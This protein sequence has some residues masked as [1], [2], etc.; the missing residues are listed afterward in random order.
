LYALDTELGLPEG[1]TKAE[2]KEA[3][4]GH[5]LAEVRLMGRYER[6]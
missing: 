3:M 2:V 1:S 4:E 6:V 5:I